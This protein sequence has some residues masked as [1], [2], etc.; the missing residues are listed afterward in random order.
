M[1]L[2]LPKPGRW[3]DLLMIFVGAVGGAV[4]L[5]TANAIWIW[6]SLPTY[7][8]PFSDIDRVVA[9]Y[10][11]DGLSSAELVGRYG[12]Y[13]VPEKGSRYEDWNAAYIV[14][15]GGWMPSQGKELLLL[16]IQDGLVVKARL[17]SGETGDLLKTPGQP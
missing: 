12:Q 13:G 8:A 17:A 10:R 16:D 4:A 11:L 1:K 15:P 6:I 14:G 3:R 7:R 2:R 5:D 9:Y